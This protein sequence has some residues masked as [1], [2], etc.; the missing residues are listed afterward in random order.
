M[1]SGSEAPWRVPERGK[2]LHSTATT[3]PA[4]NR[5]PNRRAPHAKRPPGLDGV[6]LGIVLR[7]HLRLDTLFPGRADH[8]QKPTFP[9]HRPHHSTAPRENHGNCTTTTTNSPSTRLPAQK[10]RARPHKDGARPRPA[11]HRLAP[12]N[13]PSADAVAGIDQLAPQPSRPH[14]PA[15]SQAPQILLRPLCGR[16]AQRTLAGRLHPLA[17]VR[18]NPVEIISW[19]DDHSRYALWASAPTAAPPAPSSL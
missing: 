6:D 3:R 1:I 12:V 14:H 18:P 10:A 16:A 5:C 2:M 4:R 17:A 19:I 11:H 8:V 13:P 9:I 15:T 7:G